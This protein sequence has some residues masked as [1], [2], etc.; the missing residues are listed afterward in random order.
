[1]PVK[2]ANRNA[3]GPI[4]TYRFLAVLNWGLE[5]VDYRAAFAA[6]AF[7]LLLPLLIWTNLD[8]ANATNRFRFRVRL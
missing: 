5:A 6:S 2:Q 3:S 1:M 4:L 8:A 7:A